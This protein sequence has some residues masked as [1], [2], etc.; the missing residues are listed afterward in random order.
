[1]TQ[2]QKI[3]VVLGVVGAGALMMMLACGGVVAFVAFKKVREVSAAVSKPPEEMDLL[4][5][6]AQ[7]PRV[8]AII[9]GRA[10]IAQ[11]MSDG[12]RL[13][14]HADSKQEQVL[15]DLDTKDGKDLFEIL[16]DGKEHEVTLHVQPTSY[17]NQL[18]WTMDASKLVRV[19]AKESPP[20]KS[21]TIIGAWV[22]VRESK[23]GMV[24]N[25]DGGWGAT[26]SGVNF[27]GHWKDIGNNTVHIDTT[28]DREMDLKY[29]FTSSGNL[30]VIYKN[31]NKEEMCRKK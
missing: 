25:K 6:K 1:M 29:E 24:F 3:A 13:E 9:K 26:A 10:K 21:K 22:S 31:G 16:K 17:E 12:F 2:N 4:A 5:Y 18:G 7:R 28:D 27:L 11:K 8:G 14:L 20:P 30:V 19:V 15:A 23:S